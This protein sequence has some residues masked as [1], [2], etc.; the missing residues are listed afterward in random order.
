MS[1]D[2]FETL[3]PLRYATTP[4]GVWRDEGCHDRIYPLCPLEYA[5]G[6]LMNNAILRVFE[7]SHCTLASESESVEETQRILLLDHSIKSMNGQ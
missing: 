4:G 2:Q 1:A 3:T 6:F 7:K 5:Q